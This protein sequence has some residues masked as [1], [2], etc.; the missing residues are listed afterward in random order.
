M[1]K[2]E[3]EL[4][5]IKNGYKKHPIFTFYSIPKKNLG[6]YFYIG[7]HETVVGK[8]KFNTIN[9]IESKSVPT[10]SFDPHKYS[11]ITDFD[12]QRQAL[13]LQRMAANRAKHKTALEKGYIDPVEK[14]IPQSTENN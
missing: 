13:Q 5:L 1:I 2:T 12:R 10:R 14:E 9:I 6:Y 4:I 7:E 8:I 3:V 11:L